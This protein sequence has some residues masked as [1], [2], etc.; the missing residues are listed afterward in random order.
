MI[1]QDKSYLNLFHMLLIK[2]YFFVTYPIS[3]YNAFHRISHM[4]WLGLPKATARRGRPWIPPA[5]S[6]TNWCGSATAPGR[7]KGSQTIKPSRHEDFLMGFFIFFYGIFHIFH[8]IF[9]EISW[10]I[11]FFS[12]VSCN[13]DLENPLFFGQWSNSL[14]HG[15]PWLASYPLVNVQKAMERSTHL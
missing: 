12:L 11:W 1:F 6:W 5:G 7:R 9:N 3:C 8:E 10:V 2:S 13:S 14:D 4:K 15:F